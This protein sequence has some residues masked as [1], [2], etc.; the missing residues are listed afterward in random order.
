[1]TIDTSTRPPRT[2]KPQKSLVS[3][4][5]GFAP[6]NLGFAPAKEATTRSTAGNPSVDKPP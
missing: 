5:L 4:R 6:A 3:A 2:P 1:M